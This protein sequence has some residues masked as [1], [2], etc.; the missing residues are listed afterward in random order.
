[1]AYQLVLLEPADDRLE[2]LLAAL[3]DVC[4]VHIGTTLD[5]AGCDICRLEE[6]TAISEQMTELEREAGTSTDTYIRLEERSWEL[7]EAD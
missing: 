3:P 1:M 6:L 7:S 4:P 5:G 2:G